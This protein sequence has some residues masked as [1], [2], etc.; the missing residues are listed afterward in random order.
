M[1]PSSV[2]HLSMK[3]SFC[4]SSLAMT[5]S[6]NRRKFL[7]RVALGGAVLG[8][9]PKNAPAFIGH[10]PGE[11]ITLGVMGTG[12]RGTSVA[13]SFARLPGMEVVYLCD[14]DERNL[15]KALAAVQEVQSKP[16]HGVKDFRRILDDQSVDALVIAA[17]NHW[18]APAAILACSA[19]KHVYVEKPGSHNAREGELL[20]AAARKY[21]RVVQMGNQRRSWPRIIEG[22][23]RVRNG[24]IGRVYYSRGWYAALRGSIGK[25]EATQVPSWLDYQLWQGPAPRRTFRD[26]VIHYNW[27]WFWH[28]GGGELANNGIH[29]LD[30]CRWGLG[31]DFPVQVASIGG[32]YRWA[33]DQETPDTHVV[34]FKFEGAKTVM[35]EGLSCNRSGLGDQ[36]FGVSFHG[37]EGTMVISG[38]GYAIYDPNN[39]PVEELVTDAKD[40]PVEVT[41]SGFG[42]DSSHMNNFLDSIRSGGRPNSDIEE[43]QKSSLLCHLGNIAYR[44]GRTLNCDPKNGRISGDAEAMGLW[45]RE[46]QTGWEPK[47]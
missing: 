21:N 24:A 18:Q 6:I 19:G 14:V 42:G 5:E 28:W 13:R 4:F 27:H 44:T 12:G 37:E 30:L 11:K 20:V 39:K 23:E 31:V 43:G 2:A 47:V 22:I 32:R 16:P 10:K 1:R 41:G 46:Y 38:T 33:D 35:W 40:R 26:N 34:T 17:P 36:G 25:G 29:A 3:S 15:T 8:T 9:A 7:G 45:G